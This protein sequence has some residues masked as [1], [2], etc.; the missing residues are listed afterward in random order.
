MYAKR[1]YRKKR[2]SR[3]R[4]TSRRPRTSRGV[5]KPIKMYVKRTIH[6]QIENKISYY[7]ALVGVGSYS[8]QVNTLQG[9]PLTPFQNNMQIIQGDAGQAGRIGNVIKT[10]R[11]KLSYVLHNTG[12][13]VTTNPVPTPQEV[14][15]WIGY[16]KNQPMQQPTD[17][18]KFFQ[19]GD[20]AAAPT[21]N[22]EDL[23][24]PINADLW[25]I[26]K[27]FR[28][29]L[30]FASNTG[31][32]ANPL[33]GYYSNNEFNLNIVK[34]IDLTSICPK[35]FKFD[36]T[37]SNSPTTGHGLFMMIETVDADNTVSSTDIPVNMK[38]WVHFEYE[39]A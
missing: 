18:S 3:V 2:T 36:D 8:S 33:F 38:Y 28:H 37:V 6:G 23:I 1:N 10:R 32:G 31:T 7:T 12:Y 25:C 39:D 27:T 14:R 19:V 5:S 22:L 34:T 4:K 11:L 20:S 24:K 26:K 30:G 29:K 9:Y 17:F 35:T 16:K 15:I 21:S 13:N